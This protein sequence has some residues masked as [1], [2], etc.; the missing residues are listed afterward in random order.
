[1]LDPQPDQIAP[2]RFWPA[3]ALAL[4]LGLAGQAVLAWQS[5]AFVQH[6]FRQPWVLVAV[7]LTSLGFLGLIFLSVALQATNVLHHRP[8]SLAWPHYAGPA[9][10]ALGVLGLV[11]FFAGR[12]NGVLLTLSLTALGSGYGWVSWQ[13][14]RSLRGQP[15]NTSAKRGTAWSFM[16]LGAMIVLGACMACGLVGHPMPLDPFAVLQWHIHLGLAGFAGLAILGMLPKLLRLFQK[17]KGYPS[18]PTPIAFA[19]IL[20]GLSGETIFAFYPNPSLGVASA[21]SFL[22]AALA[23]SLQL[24]YLLRQGLKRRVESSLALQVL[25]TVWLLAAV[26]LD[27]GHSLG[28]GDWHLAMAAVYAGLF[29]WVGGMILGTLQKIT[30]ILAW[31]QRFFDLSTDHAVPTA[32]QLIDPRLSWSVVAFHSIAGIF[33]L[34]GIL[35]SNAAFVQIA[36]W[37]GATAMGVTLILVLNALR[38]GTARPF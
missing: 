8:R 28:H 21:A 34:I 18:W 12:R 6:P 17:S 29:G 32:W 9:S 1:M 14:V 24:F 33:G 4:C 22:I 25:A 27:L 5:E 35:N 16:A 37:T 26:G 36:G 31:M 10:F 20:I 3:A 30:A 11:T 23:Y 7:H 13:L 15:M 19:A 38:R 2:R